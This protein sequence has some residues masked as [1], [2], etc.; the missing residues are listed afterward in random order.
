MYDKIKTYP[1]KL[2][3]KW[4]VILSLIYYIIFA[5]FTVVIITEYFTCYYIYNN[6][7]FRQ[8]DAINIAIMA[9]IFAIVHFALFFLFQRAKRKYYTIY[10]KDEY[11][12]LYKIRSRC[13]LPS[14]NNK[15]R[16][17]TYS[18]ALSLNKKLVYRLMTDKDYYPFWFKRTKYKDVYLIKSKKRYVILGAYIEDKNNDPKDVKFKV[19]KYFEGY[20]EFVDSIVPIDL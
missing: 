3:Q 7:K 13:C 15:A 16:G 6:P 20:D 2:S 8:E 10:A 1:V 4:N 18:H 19:Y 12:S 17:E 14:F 11:G 9:T 5:Y